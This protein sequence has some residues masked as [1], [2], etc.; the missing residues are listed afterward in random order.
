MLTTKQNQHISYKLK[1]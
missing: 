1:Y